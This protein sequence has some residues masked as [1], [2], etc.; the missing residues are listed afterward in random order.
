MNHNSY[1]KEIIAIVI[2]GILL[3]ILET[4]RRWDNLLSYAYLDDVILVSLA[5]IAAFYLYKKTFFGQ[6]FWLFTCGY[7]LCLIIGSFIHSWRRI[8]DIDASGFPTSQVLVI[9]A[10]MFILIVFLGI[11]AFRLLMQN[12]FEV[13]ELKGEKV[14]I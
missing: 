12:R 1:K 8:N 5:F 10:G 9:K 11:R 7:G 2:L 14:V 3:I 13:T 4:W 6:L